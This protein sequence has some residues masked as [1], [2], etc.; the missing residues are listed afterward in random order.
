MIKQ[1]GKQT[2]KKILRQACTLL[3][4]V[5]GMRIIGIVGMVVVATAAHLLLEGGILDIAPLH[6]LDYM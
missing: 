3:R 2:D 5:F 6:C 4:K 1:A